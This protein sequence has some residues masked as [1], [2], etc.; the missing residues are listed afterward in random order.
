MLAWMAVLVYGANYLYENSSVII[1]VGLKAL[2]LLF[3]LLAGSF[4]VLRIVY[5]KNWMVKAGA[6]FYFGKGLIDATESLIR[7]IRNRDVKDR[8]VAEIASYL[9]W[10]LT[11]IGIFAGLIAA[12]PLALLWRQN[13]LIQSQNEL[14]NSQNE[15]FRYQNT[16]IDSQLVMFRYQN[17]RI[18]QQ[19][20]FLEEQTELFRTQDRRFQLQ[21]EL[22]RDQN[23]S[24]NKQTEFLSEQTGLYRNQN[25][26]LTE[27]IL[28]EIMKEVGE[29]I[30][31]QKRDTNSAAE[32]GYSLNAP[33]IAR[34]ATVSQ[35]FLPYRLLEDDTLTA[36]AFSPERARLLLF[37]IKSNLS[38]DTYEELFSSCN[39]SYAFLQ[40]AQLDGT[41]LSGA[42]LSF[43]NLKNADLNYSILSNADLQGA[44]VVGSSLHWAH[45]NGVNFAGANLE[46]ADLTGA[47]LESAFLDK[48]NLNGVNLRLA[49]LQNLR[50]SPE[51]KSFDEFMRRSAEMRLLLGL[52]HLRKAS[53]LYE[54]FQLSPPLE[55]LLR[56]ERPC[57]FKQE[58]CY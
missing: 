51:S 31:E 53:N 30:I 41:N 23:I 10:R 20:T 57:L 38:P 54:S 47:N 37:L 26:L 35:G 49:Y 55:K 34:I 42:N 27:Q 33:L 15:L 29:E 50:F 6:G 56:Q 24:T 12:I 8:T 21:N 13:N 7:E 48:T 43:A 4:M 11:R 9:V 32:D 36:N 2:G 45:L 25:R 22:L 16:R 52:Q 28:N 19:T 44:V 40:N 3:M 39:F 14:V 46:K 5:G 18:N 58:G 1:D 17:E